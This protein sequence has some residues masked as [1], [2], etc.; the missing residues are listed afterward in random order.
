[1]T[2]N[3]KLVPV[4]LLLLLLFFSCNN[5]PNVKSSKWLLSTTTATVDTILRNIKARLPISD[6]REAI[7]S[8]LDID[9]CEQLTDNDIQLIA[10]KSTN[11][12]L[13]S[14]GLPTYSCPSSDI[15][16]CTKNMK[17]NNDFSTYTMFKLDV[18]RLCDS[19]ERANTL[20]TARETIQ[21]ISINQNQ[22][23]QKLTHITEGVT[24]MESGMEE[25]V[26]T[27]MHIQDGL[28]KSLEIGQ[29]VLETQ[30]K[31]RDT[32][33]TALQQLKDESGVVNSEIVKQQKK[34]VEQLNKLDHLS[35][36]I[37]NRMG[38]FFPIL[39]NMH[40]MTQS[41]F[42]DLMAAKAIAFYVT[43]TLFAYFITVP[44]QTRSARIFMFVTIGACLGIEILLL[45]P[46]LSILRIFDTT[47]NAQILSLFRSTTALLSLAALCHRLYKSYTSPELS[48]Q[49]G[50]QI[51]KNVYEM[52]R[53][54]R[55]HDKLLLNGLWQQMI[56]WKISNPDLQITN[57]SVLN[58]LMQPPPNYGTNNNYRLDDDENIPEITRYI[59]DDMI[60][61]DEDEE[62]TQEFDD[63]DGDDEEENN[64]NSDHMDQE[65][66][67][68]ELIPGEEFAP[69][70]YNEEQKGR[71]LLQAN[72]DEDWLILNE[73]E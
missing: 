64:E 69:E 18:E 67:D 1:M 4:P 51:L 66:Y 32:S 27:R 11:C 70:N 36:S 31:I 14:H 21:A 54:N 55:Q 2:N 23:L 53:M 72:N 34:I 30:Q 5:I 6:C 20:S 62:N 40:S 16:Q 63:D 9:N 38:E 10:F 33:T 37:N 25:L 41:F 65:I 45:R 42:N 71:Q 15:T 48:K 28:Q 47:T 50:Y 68:A 3:T 73:E 57:E 35:A 61:E 26:T 60:N 13:E 19:I 22:Q 43:F 29:G 58:S 39:S 17:S 52:N 59:Y 24:Q 8:Q 46:V 56:E 49:Q 12:H 7:L 44:A